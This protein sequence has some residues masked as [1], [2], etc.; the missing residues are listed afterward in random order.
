[1]G[2]ISKETIDKIMDT[3]RIEEVIGE[4]VNLKKSGQNYKGFSPFTEERN[5]SFFVSPSKNIFKCFS[6][7]K[8][9]SVVTFLMEH[10]HYTY[11]EALRYLAKRYGIEI[12]ETEQTDEEK[13]RMDEREALFQVNTMAQRFFTEQLLETDE[14]KSVGLSYFKEREYNSDIIKKFGLGYSPGKWDALTQHLLA[15]GYKLEYLVKTGVTIEKDDKKTYD[16]FRSRVIF[17]IY[18]LSGRVVGFGGRILTKEENKPKYVNS[19]E[20][21]IYNKSAV[22]YGLNLA[23]SEIIRQDKCYLVEGYTDVIS[24]HKAGF[25]NVVSS[26]GTALTV[27]Q[28]RLIKRFTKNIT[29]LYDGDEAGIMASFR[30]I[31]MILEQGMNVRIIM[32]PPDEDPDSYVRNH[33]TAETKEFLAQEK[34]F[35][36]FKT[37]LLLEGTKGDPVKKAGLIRQIVETI[38]LIP[39]SIYRN[40]YIKECGSILDVPEQVL[41]N[42]LNK[43]L[44]K[45]FKKD[46]PDEQAYYPDTEPVSIPQPRDVDHTDSEFQEKEII[47]LLLQYGNEEIVKERE[48][49]EAEGISRKEEISVMVGRYLVSSINTDDLNFNN[50]VYQ[51]IFDEYYQILNQGKQPDEKDFINHEMEQVRS[52]AAD[53]LSS[54]YLLSENWE[55]NKIYVTTE[56]GRL[57]RLVDSSLLAFKIKKV[58]AQISRLQEQIKGKSSDDDLD[59]LL[60]EMKGLKNISR[61]FNADLSRIITH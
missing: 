28:I 27:D 6:S 45:K 11:P 36:R 46:Q 9:G 49:E 24:M 33:R 20:S 38:S 17:P 2:M 13:E 53:L 42:E 60:R 37:S 22:L 5:P 15:E 39:D 18:N 35:I 30:G 56:A 14:G 23:K 25:E 4:F 34:D 3:V 58:E 41:I 61:K 44:R 48:V 52:M 12:E 59:F 29:I 57:N 40:V 10:E 21:E 50:A 7:N 8:G 31:D 16:R 19:P 26:S 54:Q 1:M 43:I 55:K 51:M 32:F 47:R